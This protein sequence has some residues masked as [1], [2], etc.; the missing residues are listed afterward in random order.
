MF[1]PHI[2]IVEY[3]TSNRA[4]IN[5]SWFVLSTTV[6]T[7]KPSDNHNLADQRGDQI[8]ALFGSGPNTVL[9]ENV[10][11][12]G[13]TA[14][15]L[16]EGHACEQCW[17]YARNKDEYEQAVLTTHGVKPTIKNHV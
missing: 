13:L 11:V 1:F 10:E 9:D 4:T 12:H 16:M 8:Y 3:F 5:Q 6:D 14:R 7:K 15:D 2:H 17:T